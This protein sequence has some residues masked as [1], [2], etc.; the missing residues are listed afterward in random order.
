MSRPKASSAEPLTRHDHVEPAFG[1]LRDRPGARFG[2]GSERRI[3]LH[4]DH[5]PAR[6]LE[7]R[8][9]NS[10]E[11]ELEHAAGS[12]PQQLEDPR[13]RCGGEGRRHPGHGETLTF[14]YRGASTRLR[15]HPSNLI[16]VMPAKGVR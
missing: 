10:R 3:R 14:A 12:V 9:V 15:S 1:A 13:R 16:R 11:A 5:L 7:Q 2:S 8:R 4:D 6:E